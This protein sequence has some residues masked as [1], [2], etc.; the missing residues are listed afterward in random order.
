MSLWEQCE[1]YGEAPIQ[2]K[3]YAK[4]KPNEYD[5]NEHLANSV[6]IFNSTSVQS[7]KNLCQMICEVYGVGAQWAKQCVSELVKENII[8]RIDEGYTNVRQTSMLKLIE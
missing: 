1:Y 2:S 5:F 8:F 4:R 3:G 7:Y 6:R